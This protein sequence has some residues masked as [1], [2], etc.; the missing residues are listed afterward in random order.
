MYNDKDLFTSIVILIALIVL[1]LIL[2]FGIPWIL[3]K[4]LIWCINGCGG[5]DLTPSFNYIY[6]TIFTFRLFGGVLGTKWKK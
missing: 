1:L 6:W 3:A 5:V 2:L 4:V